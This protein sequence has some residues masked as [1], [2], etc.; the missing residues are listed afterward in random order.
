MQ[1]IRCRRCGSH[2]ADGAAHYQAE[3]GGM[4]ERSEWIAA[5]VDTFP[6]LSPSQTDRLAFLLKSPGLRR[7]SSEAHIP[8]RSALDEMMGSER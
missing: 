2:E 6:T 5:V 8:S 1:S 3:H 7:S 4:P